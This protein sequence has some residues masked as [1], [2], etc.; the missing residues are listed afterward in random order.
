[1]GLGEDLYDILLNLVSRHR[2]KLGRKD[3]DRDIVMRSDVRPV[4]ANHLEHATT[5]TVAFH[6]RLCDLFPYDDRNTAMDAVLV[7][8]VL[9]QDGAVTDCFA[10]TV[11]VTKTT[12]S[13][14]AVFLS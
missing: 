7:L 2:H 5:N 4:L 1:M 9:E 12:V 10:V 8:A 11:K 6:G 3:S 13:V 14:K